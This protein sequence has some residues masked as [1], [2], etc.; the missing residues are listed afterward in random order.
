M[1]HSHVRSDYE[2]IELPGYD[3]SVREVRISMPEM[4]R[5]QQ[6][7]IQTRIYHQLWTELHT[8]VRTK[9]QFE[10]WVARVPNFVGCGCASWLRDY[11][12]KCPPPDGDLA[13]YGWDLHN[14]VNA[15]LGKAE[16]SWAEFEEKYPTPAA[17]QS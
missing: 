8:E 9:E 6:T 15:K 2:L 3:P 16:F 12:A 11:L 7:D 14:A 13:K 5:Q 17:S 4:S 1:S 10:S